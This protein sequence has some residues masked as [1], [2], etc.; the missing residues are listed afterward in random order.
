MKEKDIILQMV[1]RS[2]DGEVSLRSRRRLFPRHDPRQRYSLF[3]WDF[4]EIS[5]SRTPAGPS[6]I[7][8]A[9]R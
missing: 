1:T 8:V 6:R 5:S 2:E 9:I 3:S 4:W 7:T